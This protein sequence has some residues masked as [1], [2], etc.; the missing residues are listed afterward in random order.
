MPELTQPS[1]DVPMP[2]QSFA[3]PF[4]GLPAADKQEIL[5]LLEERRNRHPLPIAPVIDSNIRNKITVLPEWN[6]KQEDFA[7]YLDLLS[8][9]VEKEMANH[10]EP[11]SIC[12]D[13]ID[14]LP[15][16][17]NQGLLIGSPQVKELII[18][19]GGSCST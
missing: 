19:I 10:T 18:L 8:T 7:F 2:D 17:K 3:D 11:S 5:L 14:T 16:E 12:M 13:I 9:R 6:G 15:D 1:A 4:A